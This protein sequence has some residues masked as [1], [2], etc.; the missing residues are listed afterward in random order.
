MKTFLP[1]CLSLK[2]IF[3]KEL[4]YKRTDVA[5]DQ[6]EKELTIRPALPIFHKSSS[7]SFGDSRFSRLSL[8]HSATLVQTSG[9]T[10]VSSQFRCLLFPV[11]QCGL[12]LFQFG[13][14][15]FFCLFFLHLLPGKLIFRKRPFLLMA[16]PKSHFPERKHWSSSSFFSR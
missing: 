1:V 13:F 8:V 7:S 16:L 4:R 6:P 5:P 9:R 2:R 11:L 3:W 15:L 12:H 10:M 14:P